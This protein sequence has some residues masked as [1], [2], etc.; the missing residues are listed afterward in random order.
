M[1]PVRYAFNEGFKGSWKGALVGVTVGTA[2]AYN[3]SQQLIQQDRSAGI[4]AFVTFPVFPILGVIG[5]TI[6]GFVDGTIK[7]GVEWAVKGPFEPHD[8]NNFSVNLGKHLV[9]GLISCYCD[10]RRAREL[11]TPHVFRRI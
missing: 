6:A 10:N 2:I 7:G 9:L 3:A 8:P 5:G 1:D 4:V 11:N